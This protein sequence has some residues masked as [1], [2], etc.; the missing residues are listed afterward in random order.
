MDT[1]VYRRRYFAARRDRRWRR[2]GLKT[3]TRKPFE[4]WLFLA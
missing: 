3:P 4:A 1:G 2:L